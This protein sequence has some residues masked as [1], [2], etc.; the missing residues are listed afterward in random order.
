VTGSVARYNLHGITMRVTGPRDV[1]ALFSQRLLAFQRDDDAA[2]DL[3]FILTPGDVGRRGDQFGPGRDVYEIPGGEVLYHS[4]T[5]VITARYRDCVRMTC[6]VA[7]GK[8]EYAL[9]A[10]QS[11]NESAGRAASH[12]LFTLPLIELLRRR[13][14]YNVHAAGLCRGND[15]V[16]LAGPSG[17]GKSTLTLAMTRAG[18]GYMGDDMLFMKK[19]HVEV[20]GFPEGIDYFPDT[21][22]VVLPVPLKTHMR[23][24][25]A[26]GIPAVLQAKP[27]ALIFPRVAHTSDSLLLPVKR[28]EAFLELAP[29]VL[30]TDR[31]GCE[32]H[33]KVLEDLTRRTPAFR[34]HTG[35][36]LNQA[37]RVIGDQLARLSHHDVA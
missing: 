22:P 32:A 29:N 23:P 30:M 18:W 4:A 5:S 13:G 3:D 20:F 9:S 17:A 26:F 8:T 31:A 14:L 2:P 24:E 6:D 10:D 7:S 25:A 11:A 33:F 36:N 34:L 21:S 19:D 12:I 35:T 27:K 37:V 1:T 28:T 16:L 15:A